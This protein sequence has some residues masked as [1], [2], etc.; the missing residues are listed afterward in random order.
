MSDS[1]EEKHDA[2]VLGKRDRNGTKHAS[3]SDSVE[4]AAKK[5]AT[6][7]ESDDE[8]V[9]PMPLPAEAVIAKKK[10]KGAH[11]NSVRSE[12]RL[13]T[14][15]RQYFPMSDYTWSISPIPTNTINRLCTEIPSTFA[16][17]PSPYCLGSLR[18]PDIFT[19]LQNGL[20]Y[21]HFHR[22]P[23]EAMEKARARHRIREGLPGTSHSYN[24]RISKCRWP[25]IRHC[26]RRYDSEGL[27]CCEF[28]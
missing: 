3:A 23:A 1:S 13:L 24:R 22:R 14:Y 19:F 4:P 2:T 9:G 11:R 28:W 27:R 7:E 6:E 26:C 15:A 25:T 16:L 10:R 20:C 21:Y 8:D 12:I 17:W 5:S 18:P